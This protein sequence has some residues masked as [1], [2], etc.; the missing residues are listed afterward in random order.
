MILQEFYETKENYKTPIDEHVDDV[1][2]S[3]DLQYRKDLY[4]NIVL[5]GGTTTLDGFGKKLNKL[6]HQRAN[7]RI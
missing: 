5:S 4:K 2:Q 3:C 7:D 1:I 6:V